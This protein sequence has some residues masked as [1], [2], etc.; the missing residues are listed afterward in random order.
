MLIKMVSF[1][2]NLIDRLTLGITRLSACHLHWILQKK[3]KN[4]LVNY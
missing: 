1:K 2:Y 3:K 4:N